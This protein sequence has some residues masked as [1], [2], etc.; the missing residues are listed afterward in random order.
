MVQSACLRVCEKIPD[1]LNI[2]GT[3]CSGQLYARSVESAP[4]IEPKIKSICL[5]RSQIRLAPLDLESLIDAHHPARTIWELSGKFDLKRFEEGVK[6]RE[7]EAG[8]PCWPAQLLVSVWVYSYTLGVASA[9]AIERMAEHEPGFR[10]LTGDQTINH[11]TLSDFRVGYEEGLKELFAQFLALLETAGMVDL[12]TLLH[13]GTKVKS[14]AGKWS[15]HGRKTVEKRVKEAR[16]VVRKLDQEA[17]GAGEGIDE[18]RRAA[19]ERAAREGL[20]RAEKALEKIKKLE[21]AAGPR[22]SQQQRV[23]VSE[24]EARKMKHPDGGWSPSYNVQ[25]SSEG[26]SRMIVG[27]GVTT[28]AN[29]TQEL[30]PALERVKSNS[31]KVPERVI[32]DNGYA[33]RSNVEATTE[34]SIELIAPW[35][36][37]A[38]REAGA[39]A[40]NGIA[41][42]FEPSK[43]R[44]QRGGQKLMC[45]AGKILVIVGQKVQHGVQR[46]IFQAAAADC[47]RCQHQQKCCGDSGGPREFGRVVESEAMKQYQARMKRPE[48]K[49]LYRKRSEIAEFP[50]LW[51]KGVKGLRRFSVRGVVKAGMEAIW[52][53]LAYNVAQWM[54]LRQ[55]ESIAA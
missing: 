38:S 53:A 22:Q 2:C 29:D 43:F 44:P 1:G 54:R 28:A 35:K 15:F 14:V 3:K 47:H 33:T 4:A 52:M 7:G 48:V 23:S 41:E 24:P 32:A 19:Q 31:G 12:Q 11:H 27:V 5:E 50:H 39:C 6:T 21:E 34:Q 8:R 51:T 20:Q 46:N 42:G 36:D 30:M 13:D 49:E 40:R 10:W 55:A 16:R 17:A 18:R 45:P 26:K 37:D 9:R 25:V